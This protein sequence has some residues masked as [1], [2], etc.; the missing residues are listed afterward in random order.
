[1]IEVPIP[2]DIAKYDAKLI[3]PFTKRE[4]IGLVI[5]GLM[6][7]STYFLLSSN[8]IE[9]DVRGMLTLFMAVPGAAYGWFS[10]NG[11]RLEKFLLSYI[12]YYFLAPKQR[13]F[14]T[15]TE[16][17]TKYKIMCE[18]NLKRNHPDKYK[19]IQAQK[20]LNK[21]KPKMKKNKNPNLVGY[22]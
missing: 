21:K 19:K 12:V 1:M 7:Y 5:A 20:K 13:V 2:A 17:Q 16:F 22:L 6:A 8:G 9:G 3:G 14:K 18:N 15:N 10:Y 11:M 4:C